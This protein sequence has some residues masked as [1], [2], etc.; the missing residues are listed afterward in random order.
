MTVEVVK[1]IKEICQNCKNHKNKPSYCKLNKEYVGRKE[2]C[3][4]FK[5]KK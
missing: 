3:E 1:I 5:Q 2:T 4:R